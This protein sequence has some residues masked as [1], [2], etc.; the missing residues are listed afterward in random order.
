M[1]ETPGE[2]L[3]VFAAAEHWKDWE[4]TF[5]SIPAAQQEV[6]VL[7][8]D[9]WHLRTELLLSEFIALPLSDKRRVKVQRFN[10]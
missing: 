5:A 9:G 1:C 2:K 3:A 10:V 6:Y 8:R 7:M 4:S